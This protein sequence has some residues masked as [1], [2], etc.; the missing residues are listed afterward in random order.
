MLHVLK[1]DF[2]AQI[3]ELSDRVNEIQRMLDR[4]VEQ[5]RSLSYDLNP[6]VVERAGLQM[7]LD[8]VIGRYRER[9]QVQSI[10]V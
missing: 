3:P 9:F 1:L 4:S 5:V 8:R 2:G 10:F 6:S 7:A